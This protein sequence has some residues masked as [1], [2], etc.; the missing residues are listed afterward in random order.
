MRSLG[1]LSRQGHRLLQTG[2]SL[3]LYSSIEG[4]FI[5]YMASPRIGLSAH[6]LGA[7]QGIFLLA[8]GLL[9]PRLQLGIATSRIAFWCSIYSTL[10]IL[11][12]YTAAAVLGVG[13]E[14]IALNGQLPG[15][16]SRGSAVQESIVQIIA[17]S[18]APT[19]I[20]CFALILWGLRH[21]TPVDSSAP[22]AEP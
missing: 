15:G 19:G 14:T 11:A 13:I 7:L 12:A 3:V 6:T 20:A 4:F 21:P 18:S 9:W 1:E 17:Y 22:P 16:L 5:P 8:L 10:A 2:I